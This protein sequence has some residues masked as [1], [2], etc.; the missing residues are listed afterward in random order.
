MTDA[1]LVR[2]VAEKVM[3]WKYIS[4][5]FP[6]NDGWYEWTEDNGYQFRCVDFTFHDA[7]HWMMVVEKMKQ[8]GW[9]GI[10]LERLMFDK[11]FSAEFWK[12]TYSDG[13][14]VYAYDFIGRAVLLA[15]K[16]ALEGE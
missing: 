3:G 7:N 12:E 9:K 1:E 4:R 14:K 15:A 5:S 13:S 2:W 6:I 16:A 10:R 11:K 8:L